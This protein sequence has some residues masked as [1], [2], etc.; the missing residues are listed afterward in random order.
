MSNANKAILC[1]KKSKGAEKAFF[2]SLRDA[3]VGKYVKLIT[4]AF[5]AWHFRLEFQHYSMRA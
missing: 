1:H 4:V 2:R 3:E 5:G